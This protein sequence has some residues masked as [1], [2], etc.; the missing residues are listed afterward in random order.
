MDLTGH[1]TD[2]TVDA[3]FP[4]A[5]RRFVARARRRWPQLLLS[6]EPVAQEADWRLPESADDYSGIVTFSSGQ[7][8]EDFWEE[9][10]YALDDSA[11]GPYAVF[12]RRRTGPLHATTISG[13]RTDD[14]DIV[15]AVEGTSLLMAEYY[16]ISLLTPE[17]PTAD[18]FSAAVVNDFVG[19]FDATVQVVTAV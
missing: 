12:Y 9:N 2:F 4:D 15:Q 14:S 7:E 13:I 8:M 18:P 17:D 11:Q 10:G 16:T 6:G 1:S 3:S 19:S 5:M